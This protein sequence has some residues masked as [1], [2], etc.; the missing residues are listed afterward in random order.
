MKPLNER[1]DLERFFV[2]LKDAPNRVLF[3]DYDGT[4]AP[5]HV[6]PRKAMP[7]PGI[8]EILKRI[9]ARKNTR[10]AIVSGRRMEDLAGPL[11]LVPH[12]EVWASH[13][14]EFLI[15]GRNGR[16]VPPSDVR[17]E[18]MSAETR[19]R[20][21]LR[22]GARIEKKVAS[23]AVHWRGLPP[24]TVR[25]VQDTLKNDWRPLL[26]QQL[27]ML[28][29]DGGME[30]R[31]RAHNKGDAVRMLLAECSGAACAYLGDDITDEDAFRAIKPHGLGVLVRERP[32]VTA[33]DLWLSQPSELT[34][35]LERWAEA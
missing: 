24:S 6:D 30:I 33:A 20:P 3:L 31:A 35:F 17:A 26:E 22:W 28:P 7:Y 4:L 2:G 27:S 13:G 34:D 16:R 32:R 5:F 18:L 11:S 14:W 19:A 1:F 23:V 29:F 21:L 15:G 25:L 10:V 12:T 8:C 9:V